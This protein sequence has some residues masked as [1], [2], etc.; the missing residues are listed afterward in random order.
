MKRKTHLKNRSSTRESRIESWV[1]KKGQIHDEKLYLAEQ[2]QQDNLKI[3]WAQN[4]LKR[5]FDE[6]IKLV[7][8]MKSA[9][10]IYK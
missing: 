7:Q 5:K 3:T 10:E 8:G 2:T 6:G 1:R 4:S 9:F